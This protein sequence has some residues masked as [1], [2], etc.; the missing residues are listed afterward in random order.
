MQCSTLLEK[1]SVYVVESKCS[2][3]VSHKSSNFRIQIG[4][5]TQKMCLRPIVALSRSYM[6]PTRLFIYLL[7]LKLANDVLYNFLIFI[8]ANCHMKHLNKIY[9][10]FVHWRTFDPAKPWYSS[11]PVG[12]N[13]LERKFAIICDRAGIQGT[14][15]NHSLWAT[16]ATHMYRSGVPEKVIQE[17]TGH[18]S[19]EA[20]RIYERSDSQQHQAVSNILSS[21]GDRSKTQSSMSSFHHNINVIFYAS[22]CKL[23]W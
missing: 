1:Y 22:V 14:I 17:Q 15:T 23:L 18:R 10:I 21:S 5:S 8:W 4:M 9:F 20:L 6:F 7:A 19:V 16:S 12:K 13:T 11:V 2:L 3:W